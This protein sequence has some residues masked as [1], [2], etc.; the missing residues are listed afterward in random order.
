MQPIHATS[1]MHLADRYWGT[2]AAG[3]Y[4]FGSL[5]AR[6]TRLA[7]GSD[8]P[9]ETM[10]PLA[11]IHAA[12]TRRRADGSPGAT[13]WHAAERLTPQAALQAYTLGPAYAAGTESESGALRPGY[14]ADLVVLDR[15]LI[16]VAPM[17]IAQL[18]VRGT[19]VGGG[20]AWIGH[21]FDP[22]DRDGH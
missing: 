13:G 18:Q 1:D 22:G 14:L 6:D 7:F 12:V 16:A 3:A 17:E 2:R 9:V 20:W 19:M 4:A 10:A 8:S 5:L 21:G 15:D 11:G